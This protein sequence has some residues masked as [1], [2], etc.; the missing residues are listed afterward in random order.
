MRILVFAAHPD[1]DILGC[2]GMIAKRVEGGNTVRVEFIAEGTSCRFNDPNDPLVE[3][4]V[5]ER[6]LSGKNSLKSLGV[7]NYNF[8]NLPCGRLDQV[9]QIEINKIMEAAIFDFEPDVIFTH[10]DKDTNT[11]HR[12][13]NS[14]TLVATRPTAKTSIK[15]V[16]SYEILSSTEWRFNDAFRPN[17]FL[18]LEQSHL[19]A[20]IK[21]FSFYSTEIHEYPHPRSFLGIEAL[22]RYRGIQ[23]GASLAE[24]YS[25]IR[26][27]ET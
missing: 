14:C 9:P 6:I 2:G 19:S 18:S 16:Y 11:D 24:A 26:D 25:L 17:Y 21:A 4:Q 20:K 13:V 8:N 27:F 23:C 10:S 7:Q 15:K 1:D 22:A 12:I 5:N 3:N